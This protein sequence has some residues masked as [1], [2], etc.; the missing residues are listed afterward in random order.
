[1]V[2]HLGKLPKK[3]D[4]LR[5]T[6]C[7]AKYTQQLAP[8]PAA[9]DYSAISDLGVMLNATLGCCVCAGYGHSVQ[10]WNQ[11][12]GHAF[13]PSDPMVEASYEAIGGYNPAQTASDGSNPTDQGCNM[14]DACKYW[15]STGMGGHKIDAFVSLGESTPISQLLLKQSIALFGNSYLGFSMPQSCQEQAIW[16]VI[17][18]P[19]DGSTE[20]GSWGGH[21]V[22][23]VAYDDTHLT[24]VTWG[25]LLKVTWA[26][27][28]KYLEEA[29]GLYSEDWMVASGLSVSGFDK[30]TLLA[31]VQAL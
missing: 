30:D 28:D 22:L 19:G 23:A 3:H 15:R 14:L 4:R 29:Y 5:R 9:V 12:A 11:L 31:D 27:V 6:L 7:L 8:P 18:D 25:Q 16:D 17:P 2:F 24:V 20:P 26:F 10:Q 1:M 21:C 13:I